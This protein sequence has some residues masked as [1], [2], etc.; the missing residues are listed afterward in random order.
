[1]FCSKIDIICNFI[2]MYPKHALKNKPMRP[3]HFQNN[4]VFHVDLFQEHEK[5]NAF[6]LNY[7]YY[8][9]VYVSNLNLL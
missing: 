4:E 3:F 1:M 9:Y 8:K 2:K 5:K 7:I 6:V